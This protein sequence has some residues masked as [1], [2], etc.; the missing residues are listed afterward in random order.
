[1]RNMKELEQSPDYRVDRLCEKNLVRCFS[2][3]CEKHN[4]ITC[5]LKYM[6]TEITEDHNK[7][8]LSEVIEEL[9]TN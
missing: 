3:Y 8:L 1:M 2:S 9:I 5:K 4:C 7:I 6:C